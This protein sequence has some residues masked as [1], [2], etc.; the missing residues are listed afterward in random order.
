MN[1][2][3]STGMGSRVRALPQ[4]AVA[5]GPAPCSHVASLCWMDTAPLTGRASGLPP[6]LISAE[7]TIYTQHKCPMVKADKISLI[8]QQG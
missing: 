2:G 6:C 4:P 8:V 1:R 7:L 3:Q 5:G